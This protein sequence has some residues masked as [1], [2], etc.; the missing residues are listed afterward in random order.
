[1][2][3]LKTSRRFWWMVC[4]GLLFAQTVAV[5]HALWHASEAVNI[6]QGPLH[7]SDPQRHDAP[8]SALFCSFHALL[9][10]LLT[11]APGAH[12]GPP[13]KAPEASAFARPSRTLTAADLLTPRSR[14]PPS[15]L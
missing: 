14:G 7:A 2:R 15:L 8:E 12:D 5:V 11:A 1:M 6:A 3:Q 9:G 4:A 13:V 10:Q